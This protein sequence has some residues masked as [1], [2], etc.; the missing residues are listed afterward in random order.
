M[1]VKRLPVGVYAANCYIV[2]DEDSKEAAIID[3]GGDAD[4]IIE[5]ADEMKADVKYV[6]MTH[7]HRDHT[8]AASEVAEHYGSALGI[9]AKDAKVA[10]ADFI[11]GK[12][13]KEAELSLKDGMVI[14]LGSRELKCIET[15]GHTSGGVTFHIDGMLFTGDTLFSGS[16]GRTDLGGG[17][18]FTI[19]SSIKEKLMIL[20]DDTIVLPG[21]GPQTTV[22]RERMS[23]PYL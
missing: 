17:D 4:E 18:L 5:A 7:G 16:I 11:E 1:K 10:P 21:H 2:M 20:N 9:S 12:F 14:K 23:N 8:G 19:I 3:P 13:Y 22:K 6:L 15:P